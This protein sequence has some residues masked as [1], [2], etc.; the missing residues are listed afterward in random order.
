MPVHPSEENTTSN[1]TD[2]VAAESKD[3]TASDHPIH[4]ENK[5]PLKASAAD[6][7]S[8]GPAIPDS[9]CS[10]PQRQFHNANRVQICQMPLVPRM[11]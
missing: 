3:S 8:K 10:H 1:L 9:T 7:K 6:H 5:G 11:S 4:D 2:K